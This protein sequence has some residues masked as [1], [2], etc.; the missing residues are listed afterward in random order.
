[1]ICQCDR[2]MESA[3]ME[4]NTIGTKTT[5]TY[6]CACGLSATVVTT[7]FISVTPESAREM[8]YQD[9]MDCDDI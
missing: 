8:E 7:F 1:M 6:T 2:E 3:G 9:Q 5:H 4:G